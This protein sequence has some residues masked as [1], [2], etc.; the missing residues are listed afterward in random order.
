[1]KRL[2]ALLIF[3]LTAFAA[4][5]LQKFNFAGRM[6]HYHVP[7]VS[8]A[9]IDGG[10]IVW[11][12]GFGVREAGGSARVTPETIFQAAS[13]SKFVAA[14]GMLHLV[15]TGKLNLDED[16]NLKLKSWKVPEN[17]FTREQK[18]TLRR[19]VSHSAG[20]TIH[21]FPGYEAGVPLPTVVQILDGQPPANTKAV[22]VDTVPGTKW[23]YS[24]GGIT[25]EQLLI[26]DVTGIPFDR[27]MKETVLSKV[28]MKSSAYDQPL[29]TERR[30]VAAT[31]HDREGKA[32]EGKY[33]TY[34]EFAAAGLWTTPT[35]LCKYAIEIQNTLAG[36]SRRLLSQKSVQE[37]LTV[38]SGEVGLGPF[39]QG[40]GEALRFG[41]GGSNDGFQCVLTATAKTGQGV[42][43]MT[44]GDQGGRLAQEIA[45]AVAEEY[46]WLP[47]PKK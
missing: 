35:D 25:I 46:H 47:I 6:E 26:Q 40:E 31:A 33:H 15:E 42:A 24:G 41:H 45:D 4:E 8:V 27:Y 38:Q 39:L 17:E 5:P 12:R 37:M 43:V 29:A 14:S 36:K 2:L 3:A 34:P 21:G 20:L 32:I 22:R 18:V 13:I 7:G 10:K 16:V 19:L 9:I 44:N 11:A 28:G 1:M 23:C 30:K